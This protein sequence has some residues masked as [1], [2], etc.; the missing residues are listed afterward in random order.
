MTAIQIMLVEDEGIEALDIKREL[1]SFGYNVPYIAL[2]GADALEKAEELMPDLILMDIMLPG[3]VDGVEVANELRK[4]RIPVVYLTANSESSTFNRAKSTEPYG[5]LIKPFDTKEL[6]YTLEL[7][8]AKSLAENKI[9]SIEEKFK[10]LADNSSDMIYR[11]NLDDGSFDYVNPAAETITGYT[12][13]DF[14][15]SN[16]LLKQAIHPEF[17]DYYQE[18]YEKLLEGDAEPIFE[19][20]IL[21]KYGDIKWLNQ[22]NNLVKD[23]YGNPVAIEGIITDITARKSMELDLKNKE[24]KY[25]EE[26]K[27]FLRAQRV[28]MM[29]IWENDLATNDLTWSEG[30]YRILGFP[31]NMNIN[32][33]EVVKVFPKKELERFNQ[34]VE[35]TIK[36]NKPY[37][38]DYEIVTPNGE[39]RYIHDEG[40]VIKDKNGEPVTMF[41]TTRDITRQKTIE[42]ALIESE[43]KFRSFVETTPDMIWAIDSEGTFKYISPQSTTIL[44][45]PPEELIGTK[46]FSIIKPEALERVRQSFLDHINDRSKRFNSVIVPSIHASGKEIILEIR[47]AKIMNSGSDIRFE[48][49]AQDITEKIRATNEILNS[50]DEK[51][52][53]L[54]EIH[55]RVKNNM[56]IISS[57][58]NLQITHLDD[59]NLINPLKE[60][61]NRV[62]T[63]AMIH[64]KLY[65]T[66]NFNKINQSEYVSSLISGLLYSYSAQNRIKA[67][68]D[69]DPVD[70][71]IETSV[72]CG[73]IINELVSNSLKHGF[74]DKMKGMIT[75]SLKSNDEKFILSV[76]DN[77]IGFPENIDHKNTNSLGLELV[78]NLVDQLDGEIELIS[79][80]GTEFRIMF[81]ELKYKERL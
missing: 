51:N 46:I 54:K 34:A 22:R 44:G 15:N 77:G 69:V 19:Y 7:A 36:Y 27:K 35:D 8:I 14:Y 42:K 39:I 71:N 60:S 58:L 68:I 76:K 48:G 21:T 20:M 50:I 72:P 66:T 63:M 53:L 64:E 29:G 59:D 11:M 56:Q 43:A 80:K 37:S 33:A 25:L 79:D 16:R 74:P 9:Q 81:N 61:Q 41:G 10:L 32:L 17:Q 31:E 40:E 4:L 57:L 13:S 12:Q 3:P 52:V 47:S 24:Q 75:V 1:E 5:Y 45:Y 26:Q 55:H 18:T 70:L 28:A 6:K 49:I 62:K 67:E 23:S 65:L 30:M 73:L 78:N 38:E 2:N